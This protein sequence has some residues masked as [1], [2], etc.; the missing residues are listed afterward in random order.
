MP[1]VNCRTLLSD[2]VLLSIYTSK[3]LEIGKKQDI[4][5]AS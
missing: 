4:N 5:P 1:G 3:R 2:A